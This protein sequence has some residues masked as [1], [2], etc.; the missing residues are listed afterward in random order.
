MQQLL[1]GR[2]APLLLCMH[3]R[4]Y[5]RDFM[6]LT[7]IDR[8][9][10]SIATHRHPSSFIGN[11]GAASEV[12]N[13][14]LLADLSKYGAVDTTRCAVLPGSPT[15]TAYIL[16]FADGDNAIVLIG[17]ANQLWPAERALFEGAEGA[18][19]REAIE[20]SCAVM[21]QR[22]VGTPHR[23]S[24]ADSSSVQRIGAPHSI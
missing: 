24:Q 9:S 13:R 11:F 16:L 10:V 21:L 8:Y 20:S 6:F 7:L 2:R 19:L 14:A 3:A 5:V 15:G 23:T 18:P 17:G 1:L 22:E 12:E 4:T